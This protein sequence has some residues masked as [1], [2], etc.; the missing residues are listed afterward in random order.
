MTSPPHFDD[1][2]TLQG[3]RLLLRPLLRSD[4]DAL[5]KAA[6]DP[7]IWAG[8]PATD[9]YKPGVF[10][11]YFDML[12]ER[13]GALTVRELESDRVIGCSRYYASPDRP[14]KI[15]IG[16]TFLTKDHWGG[17]TNFE[18]K[19]LMLG[20]SFCSFDE[21]W[22]DIAPTNIRSQK[23]TSKL[24]AVA[25]YGATLDLSGTPLPWVC[26]CLSREVWQKHMNDQFVR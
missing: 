6:S 15:A 3:D 1:Q 13:G 21:V 23:A 14:G 12:L 24:G 5:A 9:R 4:K 8:H 25:A 18:L 22:F 17:S 16:F 10:E 20:H 11:T 26:F 7:E 2:P 19:R